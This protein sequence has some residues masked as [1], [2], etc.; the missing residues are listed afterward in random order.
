[1]MVRKPHDQLVSAV[2]QRKVDG[3]GPGAVE[4]LAVEDNGGT[5]SASW[6]IVEN[7]GKGPVYAKDVEY[8]CLECVKAKKF[9]QDAAKDKQEGIQGQLQQ[10]S[11][12]KEVLDQVTRC[13]DTDCTPKMIRFGYRFPAASH[14]ASQRTRR[15]YAVAFVLALQLFST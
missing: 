8:F 1:M 10:E 9:L 6:Q 4:V 11:P 3:A 5:E 2:L 13:A 14:R 15:C 7:V 12:V